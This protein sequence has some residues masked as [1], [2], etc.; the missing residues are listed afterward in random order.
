MA[1]KCSGLGWVACAMV[2]VGM[3][4]CTPVTF[5]HEAVIDFEAYDTVFVQP[6]LVRGDATFEGYSTGLQAD[7]VDELRARSGF[8]AVTA[9]PDGAYVVVLSVELYIT[10]DYDAIFDEDDDDDDDRFE[11]D[12]SWHLRTLDG[13]EI[14]RGSASDEGDYL[15]DTA[16]EVIGQVAHR[17]LRAYRL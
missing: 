7:L 8:R 9:A 15:D 12:G 1:M 10:E 16:R 13:Q 11:V 5:S 6:V 2:W 14:D 3:A 4:G 17:Y